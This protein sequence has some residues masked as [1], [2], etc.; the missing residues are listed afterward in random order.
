[1]D[2]LRSSLMAENV[3]G[4]HP[5]DVLNGVCAPERP[6]L[7][8]FCVSSLSALLK[9]LHQI[10]AIGVQAAYVTSLRC[11]PQV[12]KIMSVQVKL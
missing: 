4:R 12:A 3:A 9:Y 2:G 8:K 7:C 5:M 1:M 10:H 11:P 6:Q